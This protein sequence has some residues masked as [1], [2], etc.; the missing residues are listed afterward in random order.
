MEYRRLFGPNATRAMRDH[1]LECV[2]NADPE[3][4]FERKSRFWRGLHDTVVAVMLALLQY[5]GIMLVDN[6]AVIGHV[7]FQRRDHECHVFSVWVKKDLRRQGLGRQLI[8]EL[9]RYCAEHTWINSIRIGSEQANELGNNTKE[10]V[11]KLH[12]GVGSASTQGLFSFPVVP[13]PGR[14]L[15]IQ[16]DTIRL[17]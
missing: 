2:R 12:A 17:L 1:T 7:F 8:A 3:S 5:D 16:R 15:E 6:N 14:W 13:K 9:I 4:E 11:A 10:V